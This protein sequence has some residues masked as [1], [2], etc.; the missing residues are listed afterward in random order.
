MAT[1]YPTTVNPELIKEDDGVQVDN[2]LK[3]NNADTEE[4]IDFVRKVLGIVTIQVGFTFLL[5][6]ISSAFPFAAAF[7][8]NPGV[9]ILSIALMITC[10]CVIAASKERRMSVPEN[11]L[12]LLGATLGE[13]SLLAC[14]AA[15]LKTVSVLYAIMA[16]CFAVGACFLAALHTSTT[17]N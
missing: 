2:D 9:L 13:A 16:T 8:R 4:H 7:F 15:D 5:C 11:Y 10:V 3:Q 14:V 12:W 17:V 6:L 1:Q